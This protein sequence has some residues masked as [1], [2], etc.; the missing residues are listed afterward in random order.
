ML[1]QIKNRVEQGSRFLI[2]THI[3]LDGDAVGSCFSLYWALKSLEKEVFVYFRDKIPYKYRFLPGPAGHQLILNTLPVD[4][5]DNVF[6]LD[7][8]DLY[9]VGEDYEGL[10]KSNAFIV[11]IDHHNTNSI[12]GDINFVDENASSTAEI[13]YDLFRYLVIDISHEMAVNIYTAVLTDTGSFRYDNTTNKAFSIC[14]HMTRIGVRP[15]FVAEKVYESHPKERFLLLGKVLDTIEI[16]SNGRVVIAY[17]TR[18]MFQ[19]TGA[20]EEHSDGFVEYLKEIEGIDIAVLIRQLGNG[21]CKLSMR[22]KD[23]ADVAGICRLFGGGGH[24]KAAGCYVDGDIEQVKK[25]F[26]E[27]INI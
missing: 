24:K 15:S 17:I 19:A 2:T 12:F 16:C 7:C 6:V 11:N 1:R 5:Y 4:E 23:G 25:R 26:L 20:T 13:M 18:E 27:V 9:R 3:D 14:E 21:R 22:S 8:G 10:K